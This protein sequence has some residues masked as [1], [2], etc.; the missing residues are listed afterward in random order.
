MI[1]AINIVITTIITVALNA[2]RI[3]GCLS[4]AE[5]TVTL[6]GSNI[7]NIAEDIVA[8]SPCPDSLVVS[9]IPDAKPLCF[10]GIAFI[11]VALLIVLNT[12]VPKP[13]GSSSRGITQNGTDNE[14]NPN[15][16][17]PVEIR[18]NAPGRNNFHR[19]LS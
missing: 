8:P 16:K 5:I 7:A 14:T 4:I 12:E 2:S 1:A 11:T 3:N 17:N 19:Y 15:N 18:I 10:K 6:A 9:S 13:T